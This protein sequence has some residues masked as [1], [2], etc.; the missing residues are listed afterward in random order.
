MWFVN[1]KSEYSCLVFQAGNWEVDDS[2]FF[3]MKWMDFIALLVW[4]K[5]GK[6][7]LV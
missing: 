5:G 3:V 7:A 4:I 2:N 1:K 6:E